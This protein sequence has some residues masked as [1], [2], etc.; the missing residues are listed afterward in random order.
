MTDL[1]PPAIDHC[2]GDINITSIERFLHLVLPGVKVTDNVG[3]EDF[4]THPANGSEVTWGEYDITYIASDKARNTAY[5]KFRITI[6]GM[7]SFL[8]SGL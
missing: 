2:P 5:C 3:L 7:Y 8:M 1:E 6:A 4:T